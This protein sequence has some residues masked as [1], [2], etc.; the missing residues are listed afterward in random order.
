MILD[1]ENRMLLVT[2]T[3]DGFVVEIDMSHFDVVGQ[4]AAVD[5]K[6]VILRCDRDFTGAE[7][8]DWLVSAT[9]AEFEFVSRAAKDVP[10]DLVSEAD[11]EDRGFANELLYFFVDVAERGRIAGAVREEDAVRV[12]GEDFG[13]GCGGGDDFDLEA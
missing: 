9:V 11:A 1:A 8:F 12:L 5:G 10:E 2:D 3:F 4:I 7:V 6:S 13:G